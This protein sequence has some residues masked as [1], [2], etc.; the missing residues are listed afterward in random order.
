MNAMNKD[1]TAS[2]KGFVN[3]TAGMRHPDEEIFMMRVMNGDTHVSYTGLWM[4]GRD[5]F[6]TN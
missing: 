3:E 4:L 6:G 5:R 1:N 2:M